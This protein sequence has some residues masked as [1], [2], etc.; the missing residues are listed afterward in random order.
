MAAEAAASA[1]SF[2][3]D[4][5]AAARRTARIRAQATADDL[6]ADEI[7]AIATRARTAN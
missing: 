6:T 2:G 4:P 5:I 7:R 1:P 3:V